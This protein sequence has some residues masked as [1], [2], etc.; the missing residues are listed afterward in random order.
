[1]V[2]TTSRTTAST[3]IIRILIWC[4][5]TKI[6]TFFLEL[7]MYIKSPTLDA[8]SVFLRLSRKE[9]VVL[10]YLLDRVCTD[11]NIWSSFP[12]GIYESWIDDI[13]DVS[14]DLYSGIDDF[15]DAFLRTED[16]VQI[17][18]GD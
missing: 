7:I 2:L 9:L 15:N 6:L 5:T 18:K 3:N 17:F 4:W 13:L 16:K 14:R 8:E 11:D 10:S 1:M 12:G